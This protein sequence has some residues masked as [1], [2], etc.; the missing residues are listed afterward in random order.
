MRNKPITPTV[1]D[2]LNRW[3]ATERLSQEQI[4]QIAGVNRSSVNAWLTGE[5][6]SIRA[7]NWARMLPHLRQYLPPEEIAE[8]EIGITPNGERLIEEFRRRV[9]DA[10]MASDLDDA[11]KVKVFGIVRSVP[12]P[13]KFKT[14]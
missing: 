11:T 8:D 12:V 5:A 1:L 14:E 6:R 3:Y 7:V 13:V 2:A 10:V 9:Q 4:A